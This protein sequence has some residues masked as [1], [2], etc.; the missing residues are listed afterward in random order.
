MSR[1]LSLDLTDLVPGD[2]PLVDALWVAPLLDSRRVATVLQDQI[3]SDQNVVTSC[4]V[5]HVRYR[6]GAA[7]TVLFEVGF[8]SRGSSRSIWIYGKVTAPGRNLPVIPKIFSGAVTHGFVLLK[9][10]VLV[11]VD[12]TVFYEFP[13]DPFLPAIARVLDP[14]A[15]G[16]DI[17]EGIGLELQDKNSLSVEIEPLRYK[18]E[19]RL[20]L[21]V[22]IGLERQREDEGLLWDGLVRF[23]HRVDHQNRRRLVQ[24]LQEL[25]IDHDEITVPDPETYLPGVGC[26]INSW[27]T[28][29]DL[30][31]KIRKGNLD[32]TFRAG[33][34]L[35]RIHQ[36]STPDFLTLG[37]SKTSAT[38]NRQVESLI[39]NPPANRLVDDYRRTVAAFSL[40]A[41]D[42]KNCL[43]HGDFHQGQLLAQGERTCILDWDRAHLGDPMEDYGRFQAQIHLLELRGRVAAPPLMKAFSKGYLERGGPKDPEGETFWTGLALIDLGLREVR[44]Q[45]SGWKVAS[46]LILARAKLVSEGRVA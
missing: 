16:R 35:A 27:W 19:H 4:V 32:A 15:L 14:E 40:P 34:V 44:R 11:V 1:R 21:R 22:Q 8:S 42:R 23:E 9:N 28:G 10:P 31:R 7:C 38:V 46:E 36:L 26:S 2:L 25:L 37:T 3:E 13:I 33:Q 29:E 45:R 20:V 5:K 39:N 18:P 43:V 12:R 6:P 41:N 24:A 30:A 17:L